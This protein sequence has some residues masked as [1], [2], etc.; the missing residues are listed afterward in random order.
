MYF[1][2]FG[3]RFIHGVLP[4]VIQLQIVRGAE[5]TNRQRVSFYSPPSR[6]D[7]CGTYSTSGSQ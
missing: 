5:S 2:E 1:T 4:D 3:Q 7:I 6:Y